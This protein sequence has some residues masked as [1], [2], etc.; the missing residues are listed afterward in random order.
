MNAA[1]LSD[2]ENIIG[3]EKVRLIS[4][5]FFDNRLNSEFPNLGNNDYARKKRNILS[6]LET[7]GNLLIE[8]EKDGFLTHDEVQRMI[9]ATARELI[10]RSM[11]G[12]LFEN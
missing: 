7:T 6:E 3:K 1:M 11:P 4:T 12:A 8:C 10:G 9:D 2:W 5:R